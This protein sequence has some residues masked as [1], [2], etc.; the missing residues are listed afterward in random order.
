M[1]ATNIP[2]PSGHPPPPFLIVTPY[3][4]RCLQLLLKDDTAKFRSEM[5]GQM[6][7]YLARG[8]RHLL[9]VLPTGGGK[10]MAMALPSFIEPD[11]I[12]LVVVPF[13]A[14]MEDL[15]KRLTHWNIPWGMFG[16]KDAD[17]KRVIFVSI[18]VAARPEFTQ[19]SRNLGTSGLLRRIILD[20]AHHFLMSSHFRPAFIYLVNLIAAGCSIGFLTGSMP[21]EY[22]DEL[23]SALGIPRHLTITLRAPSTA[24]PEISY[25]FTKVDADDLEEKVVEYVNSVTLREEER[26][27]VFCNTKAK[28]R[29]MAEALGVKAYTSELKLHEKKEIMRDW[30]DGTHCWLVGTPAIGSGLDHA[31]VRYVVHVE[32]SYTLIDYTQETGR[33]GR[34]GKPSV[35]QTFHSGP[36]LGSADDATRFGGYEEMAAM[37]KAVDSCPRFHMTR[38]LDG[39][40]ANCPATPGAEFCGNCQKRLVRHLFFVC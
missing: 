9:I 21:P 36:P 30:L 3:Y 28:A 29:Q 12:T 20:E 26:G 35:A 4:T 10:T 34:D 33:A 38:F 40:G 19:Y 2:G 39:K 14:L 7:E 5:Q 27:I 24:R 18:E 32:P 37:V 25:R 8:D 6:V 17:T 15:K 31:H 23:W 16:Q 1:R 22:E 11:G 13:V